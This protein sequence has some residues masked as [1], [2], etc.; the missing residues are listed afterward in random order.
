MKMVR[1]LIMKLDPRDQD[2]CQCGYPGMLSTLVRN[3]QC[4]KAPEA[5]SDSVA[6]QDLVCTDGQLDSCTKITH[7]RKCKADLS[8]TVWIVNCLLVGITWTRER[9]ELHMFKRSPTQPAS[10]NKHTGMSSGYTAQRFRQP[11]FGP[12]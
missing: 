6:S 1:Y 8:N 7:V 4:P 5:D 2:I 11:N 9:F 3:F 12:T 10:I